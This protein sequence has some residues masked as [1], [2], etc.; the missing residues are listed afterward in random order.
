MALS[1][2]VTYINMSLAFGAAIASGIAMRR[3]FP[4][5]R[6]YHAAVGALATFYGCSYIWLLPHDKDVTTWSQFMRGP[7]LI[8]WI[9][10]WIMPPLR[11]VHERRAAEARITELE[12]QLRRGGHA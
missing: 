11:S 6:G 9:L 5:R 10:V 7:S 12:E 8:V 1:T 4:S 3:D 2:L